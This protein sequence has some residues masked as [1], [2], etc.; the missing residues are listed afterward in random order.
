MSWPRK[1][2]GADIVIVNTCGFLGQR[3]AGVRS[4]PSAP[5]DGE[6][7]KVIVT[8]CMGAEPRSIEAAIPACCRSRARSNMMRLCWTVTGRCPPVH[9]PHLGS[10]APA[11]ASS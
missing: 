9:N 5:G 7:G 6:N 4:A 3:Q 1:H 11:G 8:G 10:G 2:D